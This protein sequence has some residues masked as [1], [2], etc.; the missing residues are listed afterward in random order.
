M[1][2]GSSTAISEDSLTS[3]KREEGRGHVSFSSEVEEEL[4]RQ[5]TVGAALPFSRAGCDYRYVRRCLHLGHGALPAPNPY[6]K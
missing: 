2:C 4:S 3:A 5:D 1:V 6:G